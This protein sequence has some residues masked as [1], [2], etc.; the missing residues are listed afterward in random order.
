[1]T[2]EKE[3]A[4]KPESREELLFKLTGVD[5]RVCPCCLKGTMVR[6]D[7]LKPVIN[8]PPQVKFLPYYNCK[9]KYFIANGEEVRTFL[10]QKSIPGTY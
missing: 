8:P 6:K 4:T 2:K 7:E 9:K 10:M 1:M 3:E 5:L